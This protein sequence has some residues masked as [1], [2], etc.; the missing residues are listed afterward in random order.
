[1]RNVFDQYDQPENRLTHAL[2][3]TLAND[4]KLLRP[5][6]KFV[7]AEGAPVLKNIKLGL[8]RVPGQ[9]VDSNKDGKEGLP[10]G[11][12]FHQNGWAVVIEAKVQVG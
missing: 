6:L 8:Q 12:F 1:M 4:K 9:D 11:C 7:G 10:D 2:M 5:F 3:V